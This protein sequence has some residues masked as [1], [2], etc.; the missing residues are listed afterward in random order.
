LHQTVIQVRQ[1]NV[2]SASRGF[3]V[4]R[5]RPLLS[6]M[7]V[8][9]AGKTGLPR[10]VCEPWHFKE[11]ADSIQISGNEF[12]LVG[13]IEG[14]VDDGLNIGRGEVKVSACFLKLIGMAP[15]NLADIL[16]KT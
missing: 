11:S 1:H 7:G 6:C 3:R 12:G 5:D 4:E 8:N 15:G 2:I 13:E 9:Q 16:L 10:W 14:Y